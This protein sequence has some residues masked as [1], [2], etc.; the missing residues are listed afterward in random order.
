MYPRKD[1]PNK[2]LEA[3]IA[4]WERDTDV[5][6]KST[7]ESIPVTTQHVLLLDMCPSQLRYLVK[8][9]DGM[10]G[11]IDLAAIRRDITDY[12]Y[13]EQSRGKGGRIAALEE[14]AAHAAA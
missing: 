13:A 6:L 11:S 12:L 10:R 3:A 7:G 4:V 2:D 8:M 1:V 5:Y 14:D 9:L